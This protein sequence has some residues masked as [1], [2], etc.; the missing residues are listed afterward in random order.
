[1]QLQAQYLAPSV[2]LIPMAPLLDSKHQH[3]QLHVHQTPIQQLVVQ[4]ALIVNAKLIHS[5]IQE[6]PQ[7]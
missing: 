5:A 6:Q 4:L 2:Q 1:M 7:S 3:V